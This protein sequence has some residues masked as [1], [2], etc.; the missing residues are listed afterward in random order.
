MTSHR[1]GGQALAILGPFHGVG[2]SWGHPAGTDLGM[3]LLGRFLGL[4]GTL[5]ASE[6]TQRVRAKEL[7]LASATK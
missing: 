2:H 3:G 7:G 5:W 4:L 6:K 1:L